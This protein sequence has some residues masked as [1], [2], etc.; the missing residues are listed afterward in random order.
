ME[1]LIFIGLP[2]SGKTSYY[3]KE[4]FNSH[5]RIALDQL[6]T[7]RKMTSLIEWCL[8]HQMRC[9]IDNTNVTIE[10]RRELLDRFKSK[11]YS[12]KGVFF[13]VD[14][15]KCIER[16]SK[17]LGKHRIKEVGIYTKYKELQKP[18]LNEGFDE[19]ITI[20]R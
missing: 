2:G 17:R 8:V 9:V 16:N 5:L 14:T 18:T 15:A 12:V 7:R 13:D 3:Q 4:Y 6:N 11:K 10:E 1:C 20:N 19:I